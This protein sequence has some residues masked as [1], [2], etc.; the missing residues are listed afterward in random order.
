M[1]TGMKIVKL[2]KVISSDEAILYDVKFISKV[3]ITYNNYVSATW[4]NES[5]GNIEINYSNRK[6]KTINGFLQFLSQRNK[7]IV[8]L[9]ANSKTE[10]TSLIYSND[11]LN[12]IKPDDYGL[13]ELIM[14]ADTQNME[15]LYLW[16]KN[17]CDF[18]NF[19]YGYC[20]DLQ[21]NQ[22]LF[23]EI[24]DKKSFFTSLFSVTQRVTSEQIES[25]K[26][27]QEF[28]LKVKQG[29]IPRFYKINIWNNQQL[30]RAMKEKLVIDKMIK[31]NDNLNIVEISDIT[32][33][34]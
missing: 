22:D 28:L 24:I 18:F 33:I 14:K 23:S 3:L 1:K 21:K 7:E 20:F 19:D 26:R 13:I 30:E 17:T 10:K 27:R 8:F 32:N 4:L 31:L 11:L 34:Q 16:I 2:Y 6:W 9:I 15:N 12:Q 5:V 29:V 25:E